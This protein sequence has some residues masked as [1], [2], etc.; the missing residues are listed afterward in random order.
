MRS[1]HD[2]RD[3]LG[4][5]HMLTFTVTGPYNPGGSGDTPSRQRIFACRPAANATPQAEEACATRIIS[6]LARRAYRGQATDAD[7]QRLMTFYRE[8]RQQ[9]GFEA[10]IEAGVQRILASPKFIFRVERD[11][12]TVKVGE[13]YAITDLELASRLA[14]FLWSSVPDDQLLQVASQGRLR[15]PGVIERAGQADA[16]RSEGRAAVHQL[17]RPVAVPAQSADAAAE[18]DGVPGFRRQ[19][20][21]RPRARGVDVLRQHPAR[22]SQR[23]GPD[24]RRLHVRQRARWRSTTASP[25]S[26]AAAGGR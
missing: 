10:G 16:R 8:A 2:P 11:P 17:R 3:P 23:H 24:E 14:F 6:G 25:T 21:R 22:G 20:A 12:Q 26:T 18:L 5:P 4:I 15:A 1:S 7:T 19:P 9:G 13:A